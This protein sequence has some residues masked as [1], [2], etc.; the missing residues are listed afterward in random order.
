MRAYDA[1]NQIAKFK[2][3]QYQQRDISPNLVLTKVTTIQYTM[4]CLLHCP[5]R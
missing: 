3:H 1:N 4:S 5:T 2:F